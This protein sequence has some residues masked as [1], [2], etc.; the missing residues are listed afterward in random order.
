MV[1]KYTTEEVRQIVGDA[2]C[3]DPDDPAHKNGC[4]G[5][6]IFDRWLR[7]HDAQVLRDAADAYASGRLTGVF[8]GRD[9]YTRAW[10]R[11]RAD[12]MEGKTDDE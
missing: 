6:A 1:S 12:E 9:D 5:D 2:L 10:L 3:P 8:Y 11:A 7:A 4:P